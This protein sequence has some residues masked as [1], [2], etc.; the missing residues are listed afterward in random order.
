MRNTRTYQQR[1]QGL[2]LAINYIF[3]SILKDVYTLGRAL[4]GTGPGQEKPLPRVSYH[5]SEV[6]ARHTFCNRLG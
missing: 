3:S 5:K 6:G 1:K 4:T 2:H